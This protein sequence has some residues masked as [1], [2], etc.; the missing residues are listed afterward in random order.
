[1]EINQ[2]VFA[3][4]IVSN[5]FLLGFKGMDFPRIIIVKNCIITVTLKVC[6]Q[7]G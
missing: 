4:I 2:F 6:F 7:N 5:T 3:L 1:M